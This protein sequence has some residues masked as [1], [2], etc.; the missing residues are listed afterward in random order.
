MEAATG[1]PNR[2]PIG[3]G[4]WTYGYRGVLGISA[5][6]D[7]FTGYDN[8]LYDTWVEDGEGNLVF[9]PEGGTPALTKE[10]KLY[11][12]DTAIKRWQAFRRRIEEE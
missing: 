8:S 3:G 9:S 6:G 5:E 1:R 10:Q 4:L 11:I 7:V 2:I 12:C